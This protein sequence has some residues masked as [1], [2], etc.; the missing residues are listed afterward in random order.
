MNYQRWTDDETA[1]LL[2]HVADVR[3]SGRH[4]QTELCHI[5]ARRMK[6]TADRVR[7]RLAWLDMT[8]EPREAVRRRI[9]DY[10]RGKRIRKP[11]ECIVAD[12]PINDVSL[13]ERD[14]RMSA[15]RSITA[16]VLGDPEPGRRWPDGR[17][18]P[19]VTG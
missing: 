3:A 19:T 16:F 15:P 8:P 4:T 1:E 7:T 13:R 12:P 6:R 10:R 17:S 9:R 2:E 14:R 18:A 11:R 5:V